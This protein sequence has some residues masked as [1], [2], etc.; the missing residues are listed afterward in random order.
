MSIVDLFTKKEA[1]VSI[2]IGASAIRLLEFDISQP[3]PLLKNFGVEKFSR[4]IFA[5]NEIR[6]FETV[7]ER[8]SALLERCTPSAKRAI[9]TLPGPSVFVKKLML[10]K[11]PLKELSEQVEMEASSVIPHNIEDVMM[12]FHVIGEEDGQLK[13]L[14]VAAKNETVDSFMECFAEV[15]LEPII[16]DVDYFALQNSFELSYP[17]LVSQTV[18]LVNIGARYSSLNICRNGQS[19]TTGDVPVGG[20]ILTDALVDELGLDYREAESMKCAYD[21]EKFAHPELPDVIEN[22]VDY[23]AAE[24][25]K[26]LGLLWNASG[27]DGE[28]DRIMIAG[29]SATVPGLADELQDKTGIEVDIIDPLKGVRC[30]DSVDTELLKN[31]E[32]SITVLVG[33]GIRFPGDKIY[34][35]GLF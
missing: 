5:N 12:D 9:I 18:G 30:S 6:D 27:E 21:G 8:L 15:E 14:I 29:G 25:N 26:Q 33:S 2:D 24:I 16:V 20:N 13:I 34:P 19:L 22:K 23:I 31:C 4:E 28:L 17:A 35:E 11:V 32:S 7:T 1:L 10:P 3:V